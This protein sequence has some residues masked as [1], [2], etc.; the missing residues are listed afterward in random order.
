MKSDFKT[1]VESVESMDSAETMESVENVESMENVESVDKSASIMQVCTGY[2]GGIY[3][4]SCQ[5]H[6]GI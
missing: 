4:V 6:A 1:K 3:G 5:Y 2:H